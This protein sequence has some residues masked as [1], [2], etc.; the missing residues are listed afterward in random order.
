MFNA[1]SPYHLSF[2]KHHYPQEAKS[3]GFEV[4]T[5]HIEEFQAPSM[6]VMV[7][8]HKYLQKIREKNEV[9]RMKKLIFDTE[10]LH[11]F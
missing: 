11:F 2:F 1:Q 7:E 4:K 10:L 6:E 3:L 5:I 8:L 9:R